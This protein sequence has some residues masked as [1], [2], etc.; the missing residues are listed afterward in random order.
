MNLVPLVLI[1]VA[2]FIASLALARWLF[3]QLATWELLDRLMAASTPIV[4]L[5]LSG[6]FLREFVSSPF[7]DQ[8][9][10]LLTPSIAMLYGYNLY[11]PPDRGPAL[12]TMYGP[13]NYLAYSP[14]ALGNN[15]TIAIL[16]GELI[17]ILFY[18]L[19]V[20]WLH[21]GE[22]LRNTKTLRF[23]S[24]VFI[25]FCFLTLYISPLNSA[26]FMIH[27]DS[28]ALG[29]CAIAC[30]IL[31]CKKR[32]TSI[33]GLFLSATFAVLA[34]WTKQITVPILFALPTYILLAQGFNYF[35]RY[36]VCIVV[37]SSVI[38]ALIF[39]FCN[40]Q[41]LIYNILT[42][43]LRQPWRGYPSGLVPP[44]SFRGLHSL[45]EFAQTLM[46]YCLVFVVILILYTCYQ[47]F[48]S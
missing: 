24:Y 29:F 4:I 47:L 6:L 27:S 34:V 12:D 2:C 25:L 26:A 8:N 37:S 39:F 36:V 23:A 43:P 10:P 21:I 19:P 20:L 44:W 48:F 28:I 32:R 35:I 41:A 1:F 40:T 5:I 30:A 15:P 22:H 14:A 11:Y 33:I 38:S 42:V 3:Q 16:L 46:D 7:R 13:V 31:Y 45:I 9:S 18:F 17:T